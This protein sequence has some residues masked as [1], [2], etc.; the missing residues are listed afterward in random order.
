MEILE[1]L[2]L[3]VALAVSADPWTQVGMRAPRAIL[4]ALDED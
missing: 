4:V 3:G 2:F 1:R